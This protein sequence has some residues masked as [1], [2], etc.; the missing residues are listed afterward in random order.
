MK[1]LPILLLALLAIGCAGGGAAQRQSAAPARAALDAGLQRPY[2]TE[3]DLEA[4]HTLF[5]EDPDVAPQVQT[6][7]ERERLVTCIAKEVNSMVPS[8][9]A[10][11]ELGEERLTA[12]NEAIGKGCMSAHRTDVVLSDSWSESFPAVYASSCRAGSPDELADMCQCIGQNAPLYFESPAS[13]NLFEQALETEE[14]L[15]EDHQARF[16]ALL[17][18]CA[19]AVT[20]P[21]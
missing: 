16:D 11:L 20:E 15:D 10:A 1:Q 2:Y 19:D 18:T 9:A 7:E 3:A 17:E 12:I 4:L 21:S 6:E 5:R 14:T 13:F 8:V